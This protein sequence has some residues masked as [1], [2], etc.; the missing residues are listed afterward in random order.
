MSDAIF[1]TGWTE[2]KKKVKI[3]TSS[4]NCAALGYY[5]T[6]SGNFLP[7]F[8]DLSVPN[9]GVKHSRRDTICPETSVW[10]YHYRPRNNPEECSSHLP[11]GGRLKSCKT[12]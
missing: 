5:I 9:S 6:S 4:E 3:K 7:T 11:R 8:R 10:N 12:C 2:W 1:V